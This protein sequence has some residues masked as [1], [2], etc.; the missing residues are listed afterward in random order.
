MR[1]RR[2]RR[3]RASKQQ[4]SRGRRRRPVWR[5]VEVEA[6]GDA[7]EKAL[8]EANGKQRGVHSMEIDATEVA[9]QM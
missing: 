8:E 3:T 1:A 9:G 4:C 2:S 5:E 6:E 7:E